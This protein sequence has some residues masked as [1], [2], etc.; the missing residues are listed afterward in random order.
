MFELQNSFT[1]DEITQ[2]YENKKIEDFLKPL[3]YAFLNY[4][5]AIIK[6]DSEK[7]IKN[8]AQIYIKDLSY[9]EQTDNLIRIYDISSNF[10]AL[11]KKTLENNTE[12]YVPEKMFI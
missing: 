6:T 11:Y 12:K 9:I 4:P 5:K 7:W 8:G 2:K 3:D 10:L 1:L